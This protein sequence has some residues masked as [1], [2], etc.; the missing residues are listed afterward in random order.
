MT[1]SRFHF[2]S[3]VAHKSPDMNPID[4]R[5][6]GEMQQRIYQTKVHDLDELKQHNA[7]PGAWL[8]EKC[9]DASGANVSIR[10]FE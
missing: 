4:Y 7:I 5:I 3:S 9:D 10:A 6:W 8:R 2:T 1:A